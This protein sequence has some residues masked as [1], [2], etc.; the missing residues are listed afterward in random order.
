MTQTCSP[1]DV[2][3]F[4]DKPA[5]PVDGS[6]KDTFFTGFS[7]FRI[8]FGIYLAADFFITTLPF[9]K[10]FYTDSGI[11]PRA[12]MIKEFGGSA[13]NLSL[14]LINDYFLFY[15]LFLGVYIAAMFAFILGCRTRLATIL[16]LVGF[17]SLAE[18]NPIIT[19]GSDMLTQLLLLW[20]IFLPLNRYF[21]IDAALN[22]APRDQAYPT[23]PLIAI[24]LQIA[25]IY[26]FSV[27]F[28][29]A[30]V[31]W[32]NGGAIRRSLLDNT[33]GGSDLA[34]WMVDNMGGMLPFMTY[35]ILFFQV[36]FSLLIYSPWLKDGMRAIALIGA[37]IMHTAFLF[38]LHVGMFPYVC[39]TY[40]LLL[41]PD[42]WWREL[43]RPRRE[44]LSAIRI[45]YEP[46]CGFCL[47]TAR[48]LREF[49]LPATTPILPASADASALALLRANNSWVVYDDKGKPHLKWDGV[50][51]VL[52]QS[53]VLAP[54][55]WLTGAGFMKETMAKLYDC[56]GRN[57]PSLS[58]LSERFLPVRT[59]PVPGLLMQGLC[60][61]LLYMMLLCNLLS[62]PKPAFQEPWIKQIVESIH[63]PAP[64]WLSQLIG[65]VQV[66]QT[67]SL[68]APEPENLVRHIEL[69]GVLD[70]GQEIDVQTRLPF[71]LVGMASNNYQIDFINHKWLKFF[72]R[73]NKTHNARMDAFGQYLCREANHSDAT[74]P[75][76]KEVVVNYTIEKINHGKE[77]QPPLHYHVGCSN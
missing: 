5:S 50:A 28:K 73:I 22:P 27:S 30:G 14:L 49:C 11:L 48:L 69:T 67:W 65:F 6:G 55:G 18:R 77:I 56:I 62:V 16:L 15:A 59:Q 75:H 43:F 20:S 45:F 17:A 38:L 1:S 4:D 46:D 34:L 41:V 32:L 39:W 66:K 21:S 74:A 19:A 61:F 2:P 54:L 71:R 72:T 76:V 7:I 24:K 58:T 25:S 33:F 8:V 52:K 51:F 12:L 42:R 23:I 9:F 47:K 36:V 63:V 70:D 44:R 31:S 40:L 26:I 53:P 3:T 35:N 64:R 68:F 10:P 29:F 57:R 60:G 37:F 13:G